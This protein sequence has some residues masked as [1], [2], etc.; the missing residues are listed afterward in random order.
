MSATKTGTIDT[1]PKRNYCYQYDDAPNPYYTT[2][3]VVDLRASSPA[4]VVLEQTQTATGPGPATRYQ[5]TYRPDGYPATVS[6]SR[7]GL[8]VTQT[9]MYNR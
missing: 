9:F 1:I 6:F 8:P 2:G 7:N 5:Y 3:D 4:N